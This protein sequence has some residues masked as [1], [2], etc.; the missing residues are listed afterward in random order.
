MSFKPL[1]FKSLPEDELIT[2][3]ATFREQLATR[4]SIRHFSTREV[5]MEVI[6][7][8]IMTASSAPSGANQQPWTFVVVKDPKIKGE[9]RVAA[10]KEEKA[11]YDHRA[12]DEW[13]ADLEPLGTG[14]Q[15]PFLED[16]PFLIVVFKKIYG[17]DGDQQ[18][19]HYYV[20]ESVGIASGFLLTAIHQTGLVA[21]THT[22]SPM[23]FLA[24]ILNRPENEKAFLLVPVGYP[25]EDAEVPVL[26]KKIFEEV[27]EV[28]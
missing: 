19:K 9:I 21:L 27:T 25:A 17:M 5:P 26:T 15:K 16:A 11:F 24:K 1:K 14:W 8:V 12:T 7:N 2:R 18:F 20:N 3:S 10:E 13:L 4:R 6:E 22:P 23:G 28:F